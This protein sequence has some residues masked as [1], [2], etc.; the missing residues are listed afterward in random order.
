MLR[1]CRHCVARSPSVHYWKPTHIEHYCGSSPIDLGERCSS[2]VQHGT[3]DAVKCF[4]ECTKG[5]RTARKP[6]TTSCRK[7]RNSAECSPPICT[8]CAVV[9]TKHE[10]C[11]TVAVTAQSARLGDAVGSNRDF[12][13]HNAATALAR[14]VIRSR[15]LP[16]GRRNADSPDRQNLSSV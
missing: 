5:R 10:T 12:A 7:C 3:C 6:R 13:Q 15:M 1:T 4:T 8:M 2:V 11:T 16:E 9:C 14:S